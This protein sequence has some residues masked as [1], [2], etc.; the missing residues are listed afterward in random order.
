MSKARSKKFIEDNNLY[1][2]PTRSPTMSAPQEGLIIVQCPSCQTKF[3]VDAELVE[4]IDAP[5][6]HCSRCDSVFEASE[7]SFEAPKSMASAEIPQAPSPSTPGPQASAP[8]APPT[9][10]ASRA[11]EI[12]KHYQSDISYSA[13][14][15]G[16]EKES[17]EPSQ[18]EMNLPNSKQNS[19]R[20]THQAETTPGPFTFG[21]PPH[22]ERSIEQRSVEPH[23]SSIAIHNAEQQNLPLS[24][25]EKIEGQDWKSGYEGIEAGQDK[26]WL[27]D[28][29]E[30]SIHHSA[31]QHSAG[32]SGYGQRTQGLPRAR[33]A[34][35]KVSLAGW[36]AVYAV[37][38]PI[39]LFLSLLVAFGYYLQRRPQV[40]AELAELIVPNLPRIAPEGVLIKEMEFKKIELDSGESAYVISGTLSNGS[41]ES[42]KEIEMEGFTFDS[43]GDPL[44][45]IR[46]KAG[47]AMAQSRIK[48]LTLEMIRS[49]QAQHNTKFTLEAGEQEPFTLV[50]SDNG[51]MSKAAF[52]SARVYSVRN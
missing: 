17:L 42:L 20:R 15:E 6:F 3:A 22:A 38:I 5:R 11:L 47:S 2:N 13:P 23:P 27:G 12:P 1:S 31:L 26:E 40:A 19:E 41:T 48:S 21:V 28:P 50:F 8:Q 37:L 46:T 10:Q 49:T 29:L 30:H 4:S 14:H 36:H 25:S 44:A 34:P 16:E 39:A 35:R 45:N 33:M 52:F 51:T 32:Q 18:I 9:T 24:H 7:G 43:H